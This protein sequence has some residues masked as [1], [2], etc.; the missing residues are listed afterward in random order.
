MHSEARTQ[1]LEINKEI[2]VMEQG[3]STH[4]PYKANW[5]FIWLYDGM[6][7]NPLVVNPLR[8]KGSCHTNAF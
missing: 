6:G 1:L 3:G 8:P 7:C 2:T 5:Q 4:R